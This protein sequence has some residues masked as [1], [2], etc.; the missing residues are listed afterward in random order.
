M[1]QLLSGTRIY[2]TANIDTTLYINGTA[3]ANS[4]T[5][6]SLQVLGGVGITGN[7]YTGN[8]YITGPTS[9]GITFADGT[10]Q[11]T[12]AAAVIGLVSNG[13]QSN[14]IFYA[15]TSGYLVNSN[16]TLVFTSS[17]NTVMT[18]NLKI[19][20]G[21]SQSFVEISKIILAHSLLI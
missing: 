19:S 9:N 12:A 13:Y 4:N 2:G 15:N 8:V 11:T 3:V 6:G 18:S 17:N 10:R 16:S 21:T 5:T 7:L 1:A 20:Y 14:A